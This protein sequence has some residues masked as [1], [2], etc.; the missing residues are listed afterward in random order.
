MSRTIQ[1]FAL[2]GGILL[3]PATADAQLGSSERALLNYSAA[4]PHVPGYSAIWAPAVG[5]PV[6]RIAE[7]E[8]ALLGRA[9]AYEGATSYRT[10]ADPASLHTRASVSGEQALLGKRTGE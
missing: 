10:P 9:A 6:D 5:E 2:F 1:F 3:L 4:A 8:R 7:A